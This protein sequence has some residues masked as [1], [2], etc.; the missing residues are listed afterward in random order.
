MFND[1]PTWFIVITAVA[2][3]IGYAVLIYFA[4]CLLRP[5]ARGLSF[6]LYET[7]VYYKGGAKMRYVL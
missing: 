5:L 6:G 2:T 4:G 1:L 7:I 3:F